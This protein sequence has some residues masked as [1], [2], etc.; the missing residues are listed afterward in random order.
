MQQLLL[1][2]LLALA[3]ACAAPSPLA[4]ALG[5]QE[6]CL[7]CSSYYCWSS[8]TCA[9]SPDCTLAQLSATTEDCTAGALST[10]S[11]C[12]GAGSV[13]C[14]DDAF[15]V[16]SAEYCS[17]SDAA[18]SG[19][20]SCP[21]PSA[22]SGVPGYVA[23]KFF[24]SSTCTGT[25]TYT[26]TRYPGCVPAGGGVY[27]RAMCTSSSSANIRMYSDSNCL[28]AVGS[29]AMTGIPWTCQL[30][31]GA[32]AGSQQATCIT[33]TYIK[34]RTGFVVSAASLGTCPVASY[35]AVM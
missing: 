11:D 32:G 24:A 1:L 17:N 3:P 8:S 10:C 33:G 12:T 4:R 29:T 6:A 5:T 35:D 26:V 31:S 2:F 34:P 15:C 21:A 9:D 13:W 7:A 25:E 20:S 28:Q 16:T 14:A 18:V 19:A 23:F 27:A 22:P 30:E